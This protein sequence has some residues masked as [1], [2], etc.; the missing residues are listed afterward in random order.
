MASSRDSLS[1]EPWS[2]FGA[3]IQNLPRPS[4]IRSK[5]T[6]RS[7]LQGETWIYAACGPLRRW[8]L[9]PMARK[10]VFKNEG[11]CSLSPQL[12]M[13]RQ[14]RKHMRSTCTVNH[15]KQQEEM[16]LQ[17]SV[18]G[19]RQFEAS[20]A[21]SYRVEKPRQFRD[22]RSCAATSRGNLA[23]GSTRGSMTQVLVSTVSC[24]VSPK[25]PCK[26][27]WKLTRTS[28]RGKEV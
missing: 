16:K 10:E 13:K 12:K 6:F 22:E 11:M 7:K 2:H 28:F 14:K 1:K 3:L 4:F 18:V 23:E 8:F 27:F 5:V 15:S 25:S 24:F 17:S 19:S 20:I 21:G 26:R 9:A